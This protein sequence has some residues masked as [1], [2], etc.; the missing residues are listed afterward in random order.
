MFCREI[1]GFQLNALKGGWGIPTSFLPHIIVR[2]QAISP[3][4]GFVSS[5]KN[6]PVGPS[7]SISAYLIILFAATLTSP[8]LKNVRSVFVS[9]GQTAFTLKAVS[10][11]GRA[12]V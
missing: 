4:A 2:Y 3:V 7:L 10:Q 6:L 9:P 1:H 11:I 8:P 12:H 5:L